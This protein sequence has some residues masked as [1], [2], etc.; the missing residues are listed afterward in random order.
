[1]TSFLK[2]TRIALPPDRRFSLF[3]SNR[4]FDT[5]KEP[6]RTLIEHQPQ[7]NVLNGKMKKSF[8]AST[9]Q[10]WVSER[11]HRPDEINSSIKHYQLKDYNSKL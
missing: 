7:I 6:I 9:G 11:N 8:T 4:L 1:M 10:I 3:L 5:I 2:S